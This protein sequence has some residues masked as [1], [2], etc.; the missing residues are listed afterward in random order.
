MFMTN[1]KV[2]I[3][4][5]HVAVVYM[6]LFIK[7]RWLSSCLDVY[8]ERADHQRDQRYHTRGFRVGPYRVGPSDSASKL[9]Y[10]LIVSIQ[11]R[12]R[13]VSASVC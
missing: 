11:Y 12:I 8:V 3:S 6:F 13:S 10:L 2:D 9:V 4:A 1:K 5:R 7:S